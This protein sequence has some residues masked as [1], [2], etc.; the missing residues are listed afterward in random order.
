MKRQVFKDYQQGQS[1]L[2]PPDINEMIPEGHLV[3]VVSRMIDGID[4]SIL[5]A[6]YKGGG[7]RLRFSDAAESDHLCLY[8]AD[9]HIASDSQNPEREPQLYV[10]EWDEPAGLSDDQQIWS[11]SDESGN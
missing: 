11:E 10:A 1:F 2:L 8:P 5:E 9:I 6:Q 4:R 7:K 3:R